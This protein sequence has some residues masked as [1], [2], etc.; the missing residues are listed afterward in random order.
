[1]EADDVH[2]SFRLQLGRC[3]ALVCGLAMSVGSDSPLLRDWGKYRRPPRRGLPRWIWLL[4][5]ISAVAA[6]G[7]VVWLSRSSERWRPPSGSPRF[8]SCT[9]GGYVDGWCGRLRVAFDPGKLQGPTISLR[10]TV[11]PATKQPAAGALFYLEGGPGRAA[12]AAAL[13]VNAFFAQVGRTRDL[14]MVD[15]RGTGGSSRLACP[16]RYVRRADA[17]AVSG[18]L[19]AV[20]RPS[21]RGSAA[22]HDER[23]RGRRGN[24]PARARVR[25][26]RSLRRLVRRDPRAGVHAP[27]PEVRAQCRS[28]QRL[29]PGCSDLRRLRPQCRTRARCAARTLCRRAHLRACLPSPEAAARRIARPSTS[30]RHSCHREGSASTERHRL[31]GGLALRDGRERRGDP[32]RHQRGRARR[33]HPAGLNV[34]RRDPARSSIPPPGSSLTG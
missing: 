33:L 10:V 5:A 7:V 4:V 20:F 23:R 21:R 28:R 27:I 32:V 14:V 22:V 18:Y 2:S 19:R 34:R 6:V 1:M 11:L 26:D 15:Q 13:S 16:D 30:S 9:Y 25:E 8:V 17:G 31:D 29:P 3:D 24:R 12:T